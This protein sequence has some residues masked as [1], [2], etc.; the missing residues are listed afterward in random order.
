[1]EDENKNDIDNYSKDILLITKYITENISNNNKNIELEDNLEGDLFKYLD[2]KKYF[3]EKGTKI[4][5]EDEFNNLISILEKYISIDDYIIPFFEKLNIFLIKIIINGYISFNIENNQKEKI[6]TII[7]SLIPLITDKDYIYFIYNKLSKI[8]RLNLTEDQ[9]NIDNTYTKFC[10]IFEIWKLIFNYDDDLK[11]KEKYF[12]LYGNN[13]IKI[14]ISNIDSNYV[15][16]VVNIDFI[17]SSLLSLN[18]NNEDFSLIKIYNSEGQFKEIKI[19]DI[20]FKNEKN[21]SDINSIYFMI[22]D[23]KITYIIDNNDSNKEEIKIENYKNMNKIEL[24]NNFY[25]KI[26]SIQV[27]RKYK[28]RIAA[29]TRITPNKFS[30]NKEFKYG[31]ETFNNQYKPLPNNQIPNNKEKLDININNCDL[32]FC[33][34]YP[35]NDDAIIN[36]KYF[37]GFEAFMPIFKILKYFLCQN[38]K[39]EQIINFIKDILKTIINKVCSSENNLN[40]LY[41]VIIPLTG[42]LNEIGSI[43]TKEENELLFKDDIIYYLYIFVIISPLPKTAKDIFRE[44]SGLDEINNININYKEIISEK[45]LLKINSIDW[46]SFILFSYIEF[47]LLINNDIDKVPKELFEQLYSIFNFFKNDKNNNVYKY[48]DEIQKTKILIVI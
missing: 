44:I 12:S 32:L 48:I 18:N 14:D 40:N 28:K 13:N 46:Y 26:V 7:N 17:K 45:K 3:N 37:G 29:I 31:K 36:I 8:F 19:S 11:L 5:N 24:L 33:K 2:K 21:I 1:M 42:F 9:T 23:N 4:L 10:K 20:K 25:G 16:T 39:K 43:L 30:I 15:S 22:T 38:D 35:I 41:E 6:L 27:V 47:N 34:Y